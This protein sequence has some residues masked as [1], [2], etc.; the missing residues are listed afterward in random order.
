MP[1]EVSHALYILEEPV[2]YICLTFMALMYAIKISQLLKKP[3]P[4][5]RAELKGDRISGALLSLTNVLR[6]WDMESTEK[7]LYFYS[8]FMIFHIAVALTI[9][10]TFLIPLVPHLMTPTVSAVFMVFMGLAF[11]IGLRRIYRRFTVPEIKIISSPDDYFAIILMT[12]FFGVGFVTM[13]LWT[14]GKPETGW[15]WIF[16]LMTTFFLLYVPFSKISHYVLYPFGRVNFGMIFGGRGIL[17][18][19]KTTATWDPKI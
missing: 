16:F 3:F 19:S 1:N 15:M 13:W 7:N 17:N 18:K 8:E 9:G 6:P 5:E 4:P 10:S 11:L 2:Q 12:V 14:Q